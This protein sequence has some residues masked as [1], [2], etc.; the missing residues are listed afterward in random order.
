MKHGLWDIKV[1]RSPP[2]CLDG[3]EAEVPSFMGQIGIKGGGINV[4]PHATMGKHGFN[5]DQGDSS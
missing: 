2:T 5:L 1:F 4:S 3:V